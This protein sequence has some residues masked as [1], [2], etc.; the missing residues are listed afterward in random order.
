MGI[1]G[2]EKQTTVKIR[3]LEERT[4][5]TCK[6]ESNDRYTIANMGS[7]LLKLTNSILG[8][9]NYDIGNI[10]LPFIIRGSTMYIWKSGGIRSDTDTTLECWPACTLASIEFSGI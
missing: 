1:D 8:I 6:M 2:D 4:F 7:A 5:Y 9:K 10:A 3:S